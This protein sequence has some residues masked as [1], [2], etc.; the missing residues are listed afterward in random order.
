MFGIILI[1][2]GVLVLE[3]F[4]IFVN[5]LALAMNKLVH[6][7]HSDQTLTTRSGETAASIITSNI[8]DRFVDRAGSISLIDDFVFVI[9][10]AQQTIITVHDV[11]DRHRIALFVTSQIE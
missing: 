6:R 2:L 5:M 9:M 8:I 3:V 7:I 10:R 4:E 1:C 11:N